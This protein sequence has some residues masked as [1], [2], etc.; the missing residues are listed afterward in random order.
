MRVKRVDRLIDIGGGQFP[1]V[2]K[3]GDDPFHERLMQR[4]GLGHVMQ[5]IVK[6]REG[7]LRRLGTFIAPFKA[8]LGQSKLIVVGES[9]LPSA[10]TEIPSMVRSPV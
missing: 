5:M 9:G 1:L 2:V 10:S 7:E 6:K 3:I 4:L 8:V